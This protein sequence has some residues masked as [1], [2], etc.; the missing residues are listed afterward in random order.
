MAALETSHPL[1]R[2]RPIVRLP[3]PAT[4]GGMYYGN[5]AEYLRYTVGGMYYGHHET[6]SPSVAGLHY[7][8]V[9]PRRAPVGG[10]RY[11]QPES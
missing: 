11:G 4:V 10:M 1:S 5:W 8:W 9:R 6:P 3:Q 2:P 7:D